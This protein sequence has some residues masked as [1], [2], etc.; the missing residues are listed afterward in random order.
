MP[1]RQPG[2]WAAAVIAVVLFAM[3]VHTLA[4][5]PRFEWGTV[6]QYFTRRKVLAGLWL[7]LW[8][9]AVNE[10]IAS[11][12]YARILRKWGVTSCGI[13]KSVINPAPGF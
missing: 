5:N 3:V 4:T 2:Q 9:T 1:R 8:P 10:L 12:V 7:T 13:T 11:G 6:G